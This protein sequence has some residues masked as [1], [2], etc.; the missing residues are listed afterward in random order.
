MGGKRDNKGKVRLSLIP[1]QALADMA[2]V[3]EFG[4]GK[5]G[6]HN[7]R[8]AGDNLTLLKILDSLERHLLEIKKGNDI[9]EESGLPHIAHVL[10]N[11]AFISQL[12]EDGTLID[13]RYKKP[14]KGI[15]YHITH[16]D[17]RLNSAIEEVVRSFPGYDYNDETSEEN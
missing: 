7:W 12:T 13:D 2:K 5:Y 1:S 9:D 3:L 6:D 11:A 10:A 14:G 15:L 16:N 4:A 17:Q 8:L